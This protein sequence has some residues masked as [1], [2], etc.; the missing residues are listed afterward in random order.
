M[1]DPIEGRIPEFIRRRYE[2]A[3]RSGEWND[4]A[5]QQRHRLTSVEQ[6]LEVLGSSLV[7][8]P[9]VRAGMQAAAA[10]YP[11]ATSPYYLSLARPDDPRDPILPQVLTD[12]AELSGDGRPDPFLEADLEISPGVVHRYPDRALFLLTNLCSTLCRHCMRK[13]EW[14]QPFRRLSDEDM[15]AGVEAIAARPEI[16]DVLLSGGDPLHLGTPFLDRVLT[17]L[18]AHPRLDCIRFGSRAP[19]TEPQRVDEPLL[20]VLERHAPLFLNTHFNHARELTPESLRAVRLLTRAGVVV[21]N[22]AVLLRGVN[23]RATD[24]LELSRGLLRAG[25]RAYYLHH[26]DPVHGARHFRVSLSRGLDLVRSLSGKVSGLAIPR[27]VVD[28]PDGGGKVDAHL[29]R[30]LS[31]PEERYEFVSPLSGQAAVLDASEGTFSG[32]G[33]WAVESLPARSYRA[34]P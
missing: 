25:V 31:G 17:L 28:L 9:G 16:R 10:L 12:P 8:A 4:W 7:V 29:G 32:V 14:L 33:G 24:L 23:D 26:C 5:W 11:I 19:V 22:Q 27:F 34:T 30:R 1:N 2:P 3:L 13:R 21:S 15:R 6:I 20:A 18:R